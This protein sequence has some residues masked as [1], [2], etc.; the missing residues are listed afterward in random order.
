[1]ESSEK[2]ITVHM[3]SPKLLVKEWNTQHK[4]SFT[5]QNL[6]NGTALELKVNN[7]THDI[8]VPDT[9]EKWVDSESE[10]NFELKG[11][12]NQGS[13]VTYD[14]FE[15]QE[16]SLGK[17]TSPIIVN[18]PLKITALITQ[19]KGTSNITCQVD[20]DNILSHN[21]AVVY[22]SIIPA[23][24]NATVILDYGKAN[25]SWV[26]FTRL[27]T[28]ENG[29]YLYFWVPNDYGFVN[30]QARWDGDSEYEGAISNRATIYLSENA[31][32]YSSYFGGTDSKVNQMTSQNLPGIISR[33]VKPTTDF[34]S[35]SMNKIHSTFSFIPMAGS[36]LTLLVTSV[37]LDLDIIG[38]QRFTRCNLF[39]TNS[40]H[41]IC[42]SGL[43]KRN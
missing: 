32:S 24:P 8:V 38:N 22:G 27:L 1:V 9:Y 41:C 33:P 10:M 43:S 42:Y 37:L 18:Q 28:D 29:E 14:V 2:E 15:W 6:E 5:T 35:N 19:I 25:S 40:V 12:G 7:E 36:I 20:L 13:I 23:R 34:V 21:Q 26:E 3:N 30:I 4:V 17:I 16:E 11:K 31:A 39:S